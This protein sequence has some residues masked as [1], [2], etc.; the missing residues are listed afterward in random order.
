MMAL[1]FL[2]ILFPLKSWAFEA[3]LAK[4]SREFLEANAS[5]LEAQEASARASLDLAIKER[6]KRWSGS[7]R[8]NNEDD[9][10]ERGI[11]SLLPSGVRRRILGADLAREFSFGGRLGLTQELIGTALGEGTAQDSYEF[12]QG[13]SYSQNLGADLFGRSYLAERELARLT[14][15]HSAFV[16][17]E[18]V[19]EELYLFATEYTSL[20][21]D[22]TLLG[23]QR[24]TALR[25]SR[26]ADFV[27][28]RVRNGLKERVDLY[29]S[30]MA[31]L[32]QR[33]RLRI[34]G[35]DTVQGLKN[36]SR[37]IGRDVDRGELSG[38]SLDED[39]L[40]PPPRGDLEENPLLKGMEK[41]RERRGKALLRAEHDLWP[42][43]SL[44]MEYKSNDYDT[45][46]LRALERGAISG[47]SNRFL[48]ASL[49]LE[50]PL[51][52]ER[53]RLE[54]RKE[55]SLQ[56]V[57]EAKHSFYRNELKKREEEALHRL[58][59][60]SAKI[61][62]VRERR[63]L[64]QRALRDYNDLYRRGMADLD[65]VISAEEDLIEAQRNLAEYLFSKRDIYLLLGF[66][67]GNLKH[68]LLGESPSL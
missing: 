44:R 35:V 52:F 49:S 45:R 57:S 41:D 46:T 54:V 20:K 7:V 18:R 19:Q 9:R 43:A 28:E 22:I 21:L 34:A 55:K 11:G 23:L 10:R 13:L 4:L 2:M 61:S 37:R 59:E 66:L 67:Y 42:R 8:A 50:M 6:E 62:S 68:Y 48:S 3:D 12:S 27:R 60:L 40:G 36:L 5:V 25:A 51:S 47:E 29:Q 38:F 30:R 65:Q 15:E 64:A 16:R 31:L 56:R 33:E 63:G 14:A 32:E 39:G 26:R 53:E 58:S 24:D 1:I 17:D